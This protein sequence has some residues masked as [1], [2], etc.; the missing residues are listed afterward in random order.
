MPIIQEKSIN[1]AFLQALSPDFDGI[2]KLVVVNEVAAASED[3]SLREQ[4]E[5]EL[6]S[7]LKRKK[8]WQM[9][10]AND[11]IT[12]EE[13]KQ[14]TSEDKQREEYLRSQLEET[15]KMQKSH[16]S[17]DEIIQQLRQLHSLWY[18]ITDETAKKNFLHEI[19]EYITI[20][21]DVTEAK[22]GP[23]RSVPVY[24]TGWDFKS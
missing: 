12:L 24:I 8:K 19:F 5:S 22:G 17:R 3:I 11:A 18:Q 16:W 20:N 7:V 13:L 23:G 15:P 21:T 1:E 4:L 10:Y 14:H 6:E 2:E 9:A